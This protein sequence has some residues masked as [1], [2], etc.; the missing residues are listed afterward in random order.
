[1]I[2]IEVPRVSDGMCT[3]FGRHDECAEED[4]LIGPLLEGDLDMGL[5]ALDVDKG[6]E[7]GGNLDLCLVKDV[8]DELEEL[9]VLGRAGHRAAAGGG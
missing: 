7:D 9:G 4:A 6:D 1:M 8:C 5:R 3:Y 2:R